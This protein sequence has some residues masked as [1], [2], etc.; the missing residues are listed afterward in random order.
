M[1]IFLASMDKGMEQVI[2]NF[3]TLAEQF[4][5]S[6]L[7]MNTRYCF[8]LDLKN[9][10]KRIAEYEEHHRAVWPEVRDS[11][12]RAGIEAVELYRSGNRLCMILEVNEDFTFEKKEKIDSEDAVVQKWEALMGTYQQPVPWAKPG[13]KWVLMKEIFNWKK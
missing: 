6:N 13:E 2:R 3:P 5:L 9:D 4:Q 8:A 11:F 7:H 1:V 10:E 12:K